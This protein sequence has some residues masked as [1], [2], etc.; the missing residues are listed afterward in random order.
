MVTLLAGVT[1]LAAVGGQYGGTL[2]AEATITTR[3]AGTPV[4]GTDLP[5]HEPDAGQLPFITGW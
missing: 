3:I 5:L 2:L 1:L 4:A